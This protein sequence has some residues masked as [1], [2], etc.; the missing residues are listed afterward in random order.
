MEKVYLRKWTLG[1]VVTAFAEAGL[2]VLR[3]DE[4]PNMKISEIGIPKLFTLVCEK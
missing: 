1:E 2:C 3:L 4:S